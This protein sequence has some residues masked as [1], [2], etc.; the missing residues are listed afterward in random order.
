VPGTSVVVAPSKGAKTEVPLFG[1]LAGLFC[2]CDGQDSCNVMV[3][4]I[5]SV[6]ENRWLYRRL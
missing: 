6:H 1:G 3:M 4:Q 2:A 5:V